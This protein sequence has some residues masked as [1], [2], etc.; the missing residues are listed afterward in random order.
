MTLKNDSAKIKL[1]K[2]V[3]QIL[4]GL[5]VV[6]M[7]SNNLLPTSPYKGTRD[8]YP[9]EMRFRNWFYSKLKMVAETFSFEEYDGPML[10]SFELFASKSGEEIAHEQTYN[11]TDKGGRRL[12][13]RPEMTPTVARMVA[14]KLEQLHMPLRWYSI[15]N[16]LRYERPQKGRL[17]EHWQFNADIF[18]VSNIKAD[19]E[20]IHL[21]IEMLKVFKA[22]QS[23]FKVK[24]NNRRFFNDILTTVLEIPEERITAISKIIDKKN[25]I[26]EDDYK[27]SM[28]DLGVIDEKLELLGKIFAASWDNLF[29]IVDIKSQGTNELKELFTLI[30]DIGLE[31]YCEFDF[32]VIRGFDYYT[33]TVFEVYDTSKENRRALFGGGRYDDLI[34][35]FKKNS[36]VAGTGFGFGDV[37]LKDFLE[38]HN[39]I[40]K[41]IQDTNVVLITTFAEVNHKEY[42]YIS[43]NLRKNGISSC[44]YLNENHKL[45]KQL[46]F[47]NKKGYPIVLIAGESEIESNSITIKNMKEKDEQTVSINDY[48]KIIKDML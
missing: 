13:I 17:R 26:P 37:T 46:D 14:G 10:E 42:I 44:I 20:I 28:S 41:N 34:G 8:F 36:T 15:P 2:Q 32:S 29:D 38:T 6:Q 11:F 1:Q 27:N 40:P 22:D 48:V 30:K 19:L 39:L 45:K 5:G 4:L 24:I 7:S 3:T 21:S 25:K 47:A 33:G 23:M 43:N 18:G 16:L 31:E 9:D 35:L 12:A